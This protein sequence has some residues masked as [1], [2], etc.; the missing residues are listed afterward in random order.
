MGGVKGTEKVSFLYRP[1]F[2]AGWSHTVE[3]VTRRVGLV[4]DT[5]LPAWC[6]YALWRSLQCTYALWRTPR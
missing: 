5:I 2:V 6:T 1:D 4:R 3:D